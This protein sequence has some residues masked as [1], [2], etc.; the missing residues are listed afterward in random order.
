MEYDYKQAMKLE[1]QLCFPLYAAARSVVGLYSP[2]LKTLGLTYTQYIVF[3]V[4]WEK[5]GISIGDI[6]EKLMLDNGTLSPLLKRMEKE[7]YVVRNRSEKDD[8]IVIVSLTNKGKVLQDKARGVP[9]G[10]AKCINLPPEKARTL[11]SL[12]YELIENQKS[13]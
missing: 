6:C 4:L 13:K 7:G 9:E 2:L 1:N 12:L 3:M 5:D 10:V 11:Y 8:R